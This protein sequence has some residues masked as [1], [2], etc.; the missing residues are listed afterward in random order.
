[1][2]LL[3]VLATWHALAK[4]R[5]HTPTTLNDL[6]KE[7]STLGKVARQFKSVVCSAF[8]T[9]ELPRETAARA[10]R[11]T[12]VS[13]K[14]NATKSRINVG[15]GKAR[16]ATDD[17]NEEQG[18]TISKSPRAK[19]LN[20]NTYKFHALGDYVDSI[21]R[22]GPT[23]NTSTQTGESEH[24][25]VKR[26]APRTTHKDYE[27]G[28]SK[29]VQREALVNSM[30]EK[31]ASLSERK[32]RTGP[33]L[34]EGNSQPISPLDHHAVAVSQK[35]FLDI[36]DWARANRDDPAV[37]NFKPRL[38][39][40]LLRRAGAAPADERVFTIPEL[41]QIVIQHHR[42]YVHQSVRI[43]YTTYDMRRAQDIINPNFHSD[44]VLLAP[45]GDI[46]PYL[47]AR[48]IGIFH[49][50]V[51]DHRLPS[52]GNRRTE[53]VHVL[54]VR[55]YSFD[56]ERKSGW[57]HKRLHRVGFVPGD[58]SNAFDFVNPAV[59]VRATHLIPA[60]ATGL[61]S[62]LLAESRL[63]RRA[64][65]ENSDYWWYYVNM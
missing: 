4:L 30:Q 20:I 64:D 31:L 29:H 35:N 3:F 5:L 25:R 10:R 22:F 28:I 47:Y 37:K 12:A 56:E 53:R 34:D 46:H 61:T 11:A 13:S 24:R 21:K 45:K 62:S 18:D 33:S 8:Q 32:K 2:D 17:E 9:K 48:V 44:I 38:H 54:W 55:W 58:D 51:V 36:D 15:K 63:A 14:R 39:E 65:E 49:V 27:A 26:F 7:T 60:F 52:A 1:M 57:R 59:V 40:H 43:N 19:D 6:D 23:D 50:N 41:S 42:L 16:A